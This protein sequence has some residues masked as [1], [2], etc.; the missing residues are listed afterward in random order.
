MKRILMLI[1]AMSWLLSACSAGNGN[2]MEA[3]EAWT[4]PAAQGQNGEVDFAFHNHSSKAD[5]LTGASTDVA[6]AVEIQGSTANRLAS[7][8]LKAFADID[9]G[10]DGPHLVLVNLNKDLKL[11]NQFQIVL[12]FKDSKDIK[13][14]VSVRETPPPAEK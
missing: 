5:E 6:A 1:L 10:P 11:G 2:G 12:H 8:P 13:I 3:H 9:F 4:R 14:R 7:V